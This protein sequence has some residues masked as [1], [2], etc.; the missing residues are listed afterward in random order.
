MIV[1]SNHTVL[2]LETLITLYVQALNGLHLDH[3][4]VLL[5]LQIMSAL[6]DIRCHV[7]KI[8]IQLQETLNAINVLKENHAQQLT[9]LCNQPVHLAIIHQPAR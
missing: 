3:L 8:T 6:L 4:H 2:E 1:Q 5:V 9:Q 7:L